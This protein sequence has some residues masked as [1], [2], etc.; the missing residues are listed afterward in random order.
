MK[1]KD[2]DEEEVDVRRPKRGGRKANPE[3]ED[4]PFGDEPDMEDEDMG[5]GGFETDSH[6]TLRRQRQKDRGMSLRERDEDTV[7][8]SDRKP[9]LRGRAGREESRKNQPNGRTAPKDEWA[10]GTKEG[11][12][13][14]PHGWDDDMDPGEELAPLPVWAKVLIFIGLTVLAAII[15]AILWHFVHPDRPKENEGSQTGT[16]EAS[17]AL[18]DQPQDFSPEAEGEVPE[19]EPGQDPDTENNPTG[20]NPS[21]SVT[22]SAVETPD[23]RNNPSGAQDSG[24]TE[25]SSSQSA[26]QPEASQSR[27]EDGSESPGEPGA[28]TGTQETV[29]GNTAMRFTAVQESVT[30]K[31]AVNLRTAPN[32]ADDGNVVIKI[33]NG[34]ALARIGINQDTGWSQIDYNGQTLYAVTQ[35]LT[36]DL[37]YKTPVIPSDPNRVTTAGGSVVIFEDCDDWV[38]PREYVNLR[39]EPSTV[40]ENATVSCRLNYGE[41]AHRTGFSEDFGW[42]RVEYNGEVLYVVTSFVYVVPEE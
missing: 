19:S 3:F 8:G 29:P 33:Q 9:G 23:D 38:S 30:P 26:M 37:N 22:A 28:G 10:T 24:Q 36:T 40:Q 16:L 41:K 7:T 39:T 25:S 42:S 4:M 32:T 14:R 20:D 6:E 15:C 1:L 11:M 13:K 21:D 31:D 18:S 12:S 17:G 34:E 27:P 5:S 35:Y 2:W